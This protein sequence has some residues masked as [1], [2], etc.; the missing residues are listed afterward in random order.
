MEVAFLPRGAVAS[1]VGYCFAIVE[2]GSGA[3]VGGRRDGFED[4]VRGKRDKAGGLVRSCQKAVGAGTKVEVVGFEEGEVGVK[5]EDW[6]KVH[7]GEGIGG[8]E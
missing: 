5:E 3:A 8:Q 6:G 4:G 1:I 7:G 2:P